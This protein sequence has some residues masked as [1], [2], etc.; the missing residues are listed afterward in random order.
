MWR[1]DEASE[2]TKRENLGTSI[3]GMTIKKRLYDVLLTGAK[4]KPA[5]QTQE[6]ELGLEHPG[7][8]KIIVVEKLDGLR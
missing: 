4:T 8:I 2:R 6:K 1:E 7:G 3:D 5:N